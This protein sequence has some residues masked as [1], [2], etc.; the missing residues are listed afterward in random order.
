MI[1]SNLNLSACL[2]AAAVLITTMSANAAFIDVNLTRSDGPA[3]AGFTPWVTAD[4]SMP[5]PLVVGAVTL[6]MVDS[7]NDGTPGE[8]RSINRSAT[9]AGP[10]ASLTQTW[11]G[12]RLGASTP[13]GFLTFDIDG[14]A[15]G[16]YAFT[17]WH[18]D[19]SNQ[20][21]V[22]D[23][24]LSTDGGS[25]FSLLG[26]DFD[27]VDNAVDGNAGA[28]NPFTFSFTATGSDSV[29]V[30]FTN[31]DGGSS[32]TDFAVINGFSIAMAPAIPE[33]TTMVLGLAGLTLLGMRRRR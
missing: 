18:H 24:E 33:P 13:G 23:I 12:V 32:S 11:W 21:G 10:L 19:Q 3:E 28:P 20:T 7:I 31:D 9:Y 17:G 26:D 22:M 30:R 27:I 14:L 2:A 6:S 8:V 15:A 5:G 25:N 29:Q 4:R 1:S 16:D